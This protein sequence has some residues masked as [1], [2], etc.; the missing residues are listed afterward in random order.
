VVERE[1]IYLVDVGYIDFPVLG[2]IS[3]LTRAEILLMFQKKISNYV[4]T[5]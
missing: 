5:P 3:G 1:S 4:K 2:K